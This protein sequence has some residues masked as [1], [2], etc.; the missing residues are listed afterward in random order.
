MRIFIWALCGM[1]LVTS[2]YFIGVAATPY[3]Y[4]ESYH[5]VF[6]RLPAREVMVEVVRTKHLP[7]IIEVTRELRD[8]ETGEEFVELMVELD[9]SI[10]ILGGDCISRTRLFVD[11]ARRKGYYT[12]TEITQGGWHMVLKGFIEGGGCYTDKVA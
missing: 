11:G 10:L 5:V 3:K 12:D 9:K 7:K 1:L 4:L 2:G 8:F 6:L